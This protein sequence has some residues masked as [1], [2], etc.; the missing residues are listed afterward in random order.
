MD[1]IQMIKKD[2]RI[3]EYAQSC[4]YTLLRVGSKYTLKEH[5]SVR[6]DPEQNLFIRYSNRQQ[7]GSIIDFVMWVDQVSQR[8]AICK[9]RSMFQYANYPSRPAVSVPR[10]PK[11]KVM[12]LP[13]AAEGQYKR[14]FAY[15]SRTRQIDPSII[16]EMIKRK[17]LYEDERHNCVFVG[18]THDGAPGFATKRSTST[19]YVYRGDVPGSKKEVGFFVNNEAP[20]LFVVEA[21]IDALSIMDLLRS[22]GRDPK[23]FSYLALGGVTDKALRYHLTGPEHEKIKKIYLATDNDKAGNEARKELRETLR[24]LGF[25]GQVLDKLPIKK[26]WN[27]DLIAK[28]DPHRAREPAPQKL[29]IGY[30]TGQ[31]RLEQQLERGMEP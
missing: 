24:E 3:T 30:A 5:D 27:E 20:A 29:P 17:L 9:L 31:Q 14:V 1:L 19:T 11:Q 26:D 18:Y 23:D 21:P 2:V 7:A 8:E 6:I 22:N 28:K 13:K 25:S 16:S 10:I 12:E 4:G 15:L